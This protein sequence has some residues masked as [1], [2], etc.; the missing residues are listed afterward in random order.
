MKVFCVVGARPNFI[1][2]APLIQAFDRTAGLEPYLVHTGQ[3]YDIQMNELFF[4][5]LGIPKPAVSLGIGSASHA[6]QTAAVMQAIDSVMDA[7]QPDLVLVVG[8]VNST[9][10]AA[11]VASKKGIAVA[12]VEAG[13]RSFDRTMPEEI[14]RVLTDQIADILFTTERGALG[15]LLRE[16]VAEEHVHF[17]GNVMIDALRTHLARAVPPAIT[18]KSASNGAVDG[19]SGYALLT[20]H[21]PANVDEPEVLRG[22]LEA[23][24]AL[25]RDVP[26]AFPIHPRTG[27]VIA[28]NGVEPLLDAPGVVA[29]APIGYLTML[30]LMA[31]ARLVLT[32]SGGVQEETTGLG[33]PCLT[34]RTNTERPI[35]VIEGTNQV[36]GTDPAA[37]LEHARATLANPGRRGRIPELWDGHA[38]SRIATILLNL[39]TNDG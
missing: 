6:V 32:D 39:S 28:A 1:K 4:T 34:L 2:I 18:L 3:H 27:K 8:D 17:V 15:N 9:L 25:A 33:V 38:A 22:L 23:V 11:L 14:N 12:H 19:A 24:A 35:T 29:M 13:L 31:K 16:G 26:V 7:A 5:E 30:G 21:R 36:V 10:A 20:L 37:I